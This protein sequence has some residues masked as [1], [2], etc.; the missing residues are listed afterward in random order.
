MFNE[1]FYLPLYL[2]LWPAPW[3]PS[4]GQ[5]DILTKGGKD[6]LGNKVG[7]HIG[8]GI[9]HFEGRPHLD[10]IVAGTAPLP[11][12]VSFQLP[13]RDSQSEKKRKSLYTVYHFLVL[14]RGGCKEL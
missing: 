11:P 7:E 1:D 10:I 3:L 5:N 4:T 13:F 9:N 8:R 6:K 2:P 12:T 14:L